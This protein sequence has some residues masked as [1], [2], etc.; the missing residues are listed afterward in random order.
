MP[1]LLSSNAT[2][3]VHLSGKRRQENKLTN[4]RRLCANSLQRG[5]MDYHWPTQ[6]GVA[7]NEN[8]KTESTVKMP[9][10]QGVA[11]TD[12]LERKGYDRLWLWFE[13]SRAS[14]LTVPRVLLHE[15]PDEWQDKMAALLEEYEQTFTNWP[16]GIGTRVQITDGG[17]LT[18]CHNWLLDYRHPSQG[19]IATLR[20][21]DPSS[22]TPG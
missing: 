16:D 6:A 11:C 17:K 2:R 3:L 19:K 20:P 7:C 9:A 8:M 4:L 21:N 15:M 22:D 14:W 5:R 12:G 1:V 18:R 10:P 13:L